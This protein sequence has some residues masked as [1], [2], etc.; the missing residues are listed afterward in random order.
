LNFIIPFS[1]EKYFPPYTQVATISINNETAVLE[2]D[3]AFQAAESGIWIGARWLR[4]FEAFLSLMADCADIG[5]FGSTPI[6]INGMDVYIKIPVRVGVDYIP[7]AQ[8]VANVYKGGL[9]A[10]LHLKNALALVT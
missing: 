3:K 6:S 2:N 8:I 5:P 10:R 7:V 9:P 4:G 1:K